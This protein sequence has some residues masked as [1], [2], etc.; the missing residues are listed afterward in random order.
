MEDDPKEFDE[1]SFVEVAHGAQVIAR[2]NNILP[3]S[4][5]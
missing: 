2:N 3:M 1:E 5:T 4:F